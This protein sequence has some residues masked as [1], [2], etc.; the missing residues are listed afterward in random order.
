IL[1]AQRLA[2]PHLLDVGWRVPAV[3]FLEGP[4]GRLGEAAADGGLAGTGHAH[5]DDNLDGHDQSAWCMPG[6][7]TRSKPWAP[8]PSRIAWIIAVAPVGVR[9]DSIYASDD[10]ST[11]MAMPCKAAKPT[12]RRQ[13]GSQA[14]SV[15]S[16]R[17]ATSR[18]ESV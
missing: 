10:D 8:K 7:S 14:P 4:A 15:A 2:A 12:V 11:G 1:V 16:R 3:A 18:L 17:G 5:E 13:P 9:N 6:R